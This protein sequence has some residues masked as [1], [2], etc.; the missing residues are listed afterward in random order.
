MQDFH[1]TFMTLSLSATSNRVH[2][3]LDGACHAV[4]TGLE[5]YGLKVTSSHVHTKLSDR[6]SGEKMVYVE[7]AVDDVV[8][9]VTDD[10]AVD[11]EGGL[12]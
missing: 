9:P 3:P 8:E 5:D 6:L 7:P 11:N 10:A 2:L 1:W 4:E 12:D